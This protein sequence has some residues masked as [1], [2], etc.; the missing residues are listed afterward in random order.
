MDAIVIDVKSIYVVPIS[1][2]AARKDV[3]AAYMRTSGEG[4]RNNRGESFTYWTSTHTPTLYSVRRK[5]EEPHKQQLLGYMLGEIDIADWWAQAYP[6][7]AQIA[8]VAGAVTGVAAIASAPFVFIKWIR[9]KC[10][11]AEKTAEYTLIQKI[12]SGDSWNVSL[13]SQELS[14]SE[15]DTKKLLKGFGYEWNRNK[16]LYIATEKTEKLRNIKPDVNYY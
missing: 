9:S 10:Q 8:D 5:V 2:G 7:I 16:M 14:L 3:L 6:I 12:L 4:W 13:L 1:E 15:D 11:K